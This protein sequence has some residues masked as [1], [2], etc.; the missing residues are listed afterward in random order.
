MLDV[1]NIKS[2]KIFVV[3]IEPYKLYDVHIY[4]SSFYH[5]RMSAPTGLARTEALVL[6]TTKMIHTAVPASKDWG[7]SIV[8][9]VRHLNTTSPR[10]PKLII[11]YICNYE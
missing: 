10:L 1:M 5:N 7:E 6:Q 9:K 3:K 4:L 8:Q 11:P 2:K